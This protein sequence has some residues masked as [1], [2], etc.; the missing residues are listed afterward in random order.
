MSSGIIRSCD[1]FTNFIATCRRLAS[2]VPAPTTF[3][4]DSGLTVAA[5]IEPAA[6]SEWGQICPD[7]FAMTFL[8]I[9]LLA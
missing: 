5:L 2:L 3:E 9:S 6:K 8:E 4:R 1:A 7:E